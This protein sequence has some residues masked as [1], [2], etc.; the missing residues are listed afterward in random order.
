[1]TAN[2]LHNEHTLNAAILV[3]SH[4]GTTFFRL[5]HPRL[6]WEKWSNIFQVTYCLFKFSLVIY[7]LDEIYFKLLGK[8]HLTV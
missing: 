4:D 2:K 3:Y 7:T 1:M 5:L 6:L 8:F